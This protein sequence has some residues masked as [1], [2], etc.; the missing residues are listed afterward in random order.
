MFE[1]NLFV[2]LHLMSISKNWKLD[3]SCPKGTF[4]QRFEIQWHLTSLKG[5]YNLRLLPGPGCWVWPKP[6]CGICLF[7]CICSCAKMMVI[8]AAYSTKIPR[9]RC[10]TFIFLKGKFC[11]VQ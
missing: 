2:D 8:F 11:L 3:V 10:R 6:T 7:G 1:N 4:K 9:V 5:R